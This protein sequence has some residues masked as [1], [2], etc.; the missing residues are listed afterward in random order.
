MPKKVTFFLP[1]IIARSQ[2]ALL[3]F[4]SGVGLNQ[5][6]TATQQF[7]Y[8]QQFSKVTQ[9]WVIKK[10]KSPKDKIYMDHLL[11]EVIYMQERK[12]KYPT[13]KLNNV[14]SNIA[15]TEK[16]NKT[17]SIKNMRSRFSFE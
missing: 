3:D 8:K 5:A 17:D 14:P 11:D 16:P 6:T 1:G 9:S 7:R 10:I 4:N 13:P 12:D 2:L 15:P